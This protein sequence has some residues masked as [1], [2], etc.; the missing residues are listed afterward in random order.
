MADLIGSKV[1]NIAGALFEVTGVTL[2]GSPPVPCVTL[3]SPLRPG[4]GG[5]DLVRSE[6]PVPL[7]TFF[8]RFQLDQE[9]LGGDVAVLL[10]RL[11]GSSRTPC[12]PKC[13]G[14]CVIDTGHGTTELQRCDDCALYANDDE[15][16][17][18][19]MTALLGKSVEGARCWFV[20]SQRALG[21][22]ASRGD[23]QLAVLGNLLIALGCS[24]EQT[25]KFQEDIEVTD[26]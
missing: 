10:P 15:A 25:R 4:P 2:R 5:W 17:V 24:K 1:R 18:A 23:V 22:A 11:A 20:P 3:S 9:P 6:D 21:I 14:W 12:C 19:A 16:A 13:P 7:A 26:G 8:T